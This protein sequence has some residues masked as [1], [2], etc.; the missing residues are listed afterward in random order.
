MKENKFLNFMEMRKNLGSRPGLKNITELMKRLKNPEKNLRVIQIA[1]T[2]GKGSTTQ[3]LSEIL[4][5]NGYIVGT[6]T[7]P[8][9]ETP[10]DEIKFNDEIISEEDFNFFVQKIIPIADDMDKT[11]NFLT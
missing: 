6:F 5:Q 9:L 1:G 2:N 8:E 10:L 3:I 7:S 11:G 4:K